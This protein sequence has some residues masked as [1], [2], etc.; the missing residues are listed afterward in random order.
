MLLR[1]Q[2]IILEMTARGEPL[3]STMDRLCLEVEAIMPGTVCSVLTLDDSRRIHSLSAPSLPDAYCAG[4]EGALVGP[5][6]GSCGTAAFRGEPVSVTD[7][8]SD[9]LWRSV[10]VSRLPKQ[11]VACWSSPIVDACRK[12]L[13]TFA[14]YFR[15]HRGPTEIEEQAVAACAQLCAIAIERDAQ[16]IELHRLAFTD[17]L[18]GLANRAAF[19]EAMSTLQGRNSPPWGLILIDLDNLKKVND[20][21]GHMC[22]DRLLVSAAESIASVVPKE[23]AFRIGGDE[24]AVIVQLENGAAG[25]VEVAETILDALKTPIDYLGHAIGRSATM[26]GTVVTGDAGD[27][28]SIKRSA[29]L[30]LYHAKEMGRGRFALYEEGLGTSI[31]RRLGA[32]RLLSEALQEG[33]IE[34][35]YQPV[36][37]LSS[38]D[39]VGLEAL[40]RIIARDGA[41]VPAAEFQEAVTDV[42]VASE[43]TQRMIAK[44]ARH[45]GEWRDT[46]IALRPVCINVTASDIRDGKLADHFIREFGEVGI[47]LSLAGIEITESVYL[48]DRDEA[49]SQQIG[50]LRRLGISVALDDFGTGHASLTDLLTVPVDVI[51]IDKWFIERL[52]PRNASFAIIKGLIGIAADL[53]IRVVAEGVETSL[54]VAQLRRARCPLA[55][56]FHFARP[57]DHR[58]TA[59]LLKSRVSSPHLTNSSHEGRPGGVRRPK[60]QL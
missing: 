38:G 21:F 26:G 11:L 53:G 42:L 13:G 29:D 7:V 30:A 1:L 28:E 8:R 35:H 33:R 46:N 45:L 56:G 36:M 10:D 37:D 23:W 50:A 5:E 60:L 51:K 2:I 14:F 49:I 43:L 3:K 25:L 16:K 15:E 19:D 41:I 22:G 52:R 58:E 4:F 54:Q 44:V 6:L 57:A 48:I 20:T 32:I 24:L 31:T 40:C 34:P 39:I 17:N 47:P 12:V 9:P 27:V 18:T 55:Q 59:R